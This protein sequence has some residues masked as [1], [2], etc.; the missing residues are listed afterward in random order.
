MCI[1]GC[2][3]G[4]KN[5]QTKAIKSDI[6]DK[7]AS[8]GPK[9]IDTPSYINGFNTSSFA[10]ESWDDILKSEKMKGSFVELPALESIE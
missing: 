6:I 2:S 10:S 7:N 5:T 1:V 4:E 8:I 9:E 3:S